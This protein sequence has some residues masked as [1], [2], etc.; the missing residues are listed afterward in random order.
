MRRMS[1]IEEDGDKRVNMAHLSIVGSHAVNGVAF[2]HSEIIKHDI[3]R[4]FYEL[5]PEKFQNKTNG[6]TPRRW[7]L[8]CNPSL[9]DVI[10]EVSLKGLSDAVLASRTSKKNSFTPQVRKP[11]IQ[12]RIFFSWGRGGPAAPTPPR[13]PFLSFT[14]GQTPKILSIHPFENLPVTIFQRE[15]IHLCLKLKVTIFLVTNSYLTISTVY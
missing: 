4:D 3:F 1:L 2:I 15:R 10:A 12:G 7:L 11:L 5:T 8:L 6:I 9:A 13:A 14:V